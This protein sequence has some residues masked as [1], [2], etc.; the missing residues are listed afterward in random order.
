MTTDVNF[1]YYGTIT[2]FRLNTDAVR[3]WWNDNVND[4]PVWGGRVD[5]QY[6]VE[7]R[8]ADAIWRGLEDAGFT[9]S[10]DVGP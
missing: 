7:P 5:R 9:I 4:G 6:I 1:F 10:A 3:E 8:Y 2:G